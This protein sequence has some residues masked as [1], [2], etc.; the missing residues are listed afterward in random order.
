MYIIQRPLYKSSSNKYILTFE[1]ATCIL[2]FQIKIWI[3]N[4]RYKEIY[5]ISI[6]V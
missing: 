3:L 5:I 4:L 2:K 1:I 6:S